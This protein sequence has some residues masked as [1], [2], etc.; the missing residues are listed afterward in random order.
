MKKVFLTLGALGTALA[1]MPMFAAFEAHVV[2]VTATI[3]N[4]LSVPL[5]A[6]GLTFGEI[7]P[8][9]VATRTVSIALSQSF[10][11]DANTDANEVDY[12]IRQKP[13]CGLSQGGNPV[14]YSAYAQVTENSDGTF[15]CPGDYVQLPLLC[16]Y[17]SKHPDLDRQHG[18]NDG[19]LDAF[20]GPLTGWNAS[21]SVQFQVPGI[22]VKPSDTSDNWTIDLHAPCF[23]GSCAQDNVVPLAYQAASSTEHQQFGC[24]LWFEATNITNTPL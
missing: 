3:E 20:H 5:E 14:T 11:A 23:K 22:L 17:L 1:V 6:K 7:F 24:D 21:T 8:E 15:V 10:L 16:P 18:G 13:K 4:A 19:S 2:N 9:E 12:V